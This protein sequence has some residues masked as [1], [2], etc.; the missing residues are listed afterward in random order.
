MSNLTITNHKTYWTEFEDEPCL[1]NVVREKLAQRDLVPAAMLLD[2][3]RTIPDMIQPGK[4]YTLREI[5]GAVRVFNIPERLI[6]KALNTNAVFAPGTRH[7]GGK[8]RP[9]KEYRIPSLQELFAEFVDR[10]DEWYRVA[11]D[12]ITVDAFQSTAAY[13]AHLHNAYILRLCHDAKKAIEHPRKKMAE[14]LGVC[15][16]TIRNYEKRLGQIFVTQRFTV[17]ELV[18]G[19][20]WNL[21][22]ERKLDENNKPEWSATMLEAV[23]EQG[24]RRRFPA[25]RAVA[26]KLIQDGWQVWKVTQLCNTYEPAAAA[27][28]KSDRQYIYLDSVTGRSNMDYSSSYMEGLDA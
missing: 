9:P 17:A 6:R 11:A 16:Q 21:P 7:M 15:V 22:T 27:A 5:M 14:R 10:D 4:W 26:A 20:A 1:P 13:L 12:R 28:G 24:T 3:F 19:V 23:D 18:H 25:V 8:G 2:A